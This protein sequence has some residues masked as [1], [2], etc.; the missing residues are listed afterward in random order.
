MAILALETDPARA[1]TIQQIASRLLKTDLTLVR[2]KTD[3]KRALS[4]E[5]LDVVLLPALLSPA[6][7]AELIAYLS[8]RQ[9][10]GHLEMLI[11]PFAFAPETPHA[12][13]APAGWRGWI[14]GETAPSENTSCSARAFAERLVWSL[15][16]AREVRREHAEELEWKREIEE[17]RSTALVCATAEAP[18]LED[19]PPTCDVDEPPTMQAAPAPDPFDIDVRAIVDRIMAVSLANSAKEPV[20]DSESI[21]LS[22]ADDVRVSVDRVME[23][24]Q[25]RIHSDDRRRHVRVAGRYDA[26]RT[27]DITTAVVIHSLS[28]VGCFV[29]SFQEEPKG[30][31]LALEVHVPEEGWL[32][33]NAEIVRNEPEFGFGVRFVDVSEDV[34]ARL[35]REVAARTANTR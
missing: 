26:R 3:F 28:E 11:T 17:A 8:G 9:A 20:P 25:L 24:P 7:E 13:D 31:S 27:G 29:E 16:R 14:E 15:T 34:R 22:T 6:D 2:S 19:V 35:A 32:L 4:D 12:K 1:A 5:T 33:L 10:S 18:D 21:S 23:E 30:R